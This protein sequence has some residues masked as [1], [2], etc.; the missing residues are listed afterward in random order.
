[1]KKTLYILLALALLLL[2]VYALAEGEALPTEPFTWEYLVTILGA[3]VATT[4]VVQL[5]KLPLDKIWHIPT[6][7]VA[8]VIAL[9]IMLLATHFTSG[10]TW[11]NACLAALNAVI[12]ALAAYGS[13]EVAV[14]KIEE[15]RANAESNG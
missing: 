9:A 5:L 15:H 1:M 3:T 2:P 7:I 13:Y 6:R 4:L 8:Y 11:S 12:V 10:L 14:K